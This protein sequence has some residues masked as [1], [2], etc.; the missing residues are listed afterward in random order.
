MKVQGYRVRL[1]STF[2]SAKPTA[3]ARR[4]VL[5]AG[6]RAVRG[7]LALATMI[8]PVLGYAAGAADVVVDFS[9]H[10]AHPRS[11]VGF[12][13][14]MDARRPD[15]RWVAPLEPALW[16]TGRLVRELYPRAARLGARVTVVISDI[17]GYDA[18]HAPYLNYPAFEQ[19]VRQIVRAAGDRPVIYDIWGE[20]DTATSWHGSEA[21]FMETFRRAHDAIRAV[22]PDAIIAGPS[23]VSYRRDRMQRFVA[24]CLAHHLRLDV[25]SWHEFRSGPG[26]ALIERDLREARQLF[27][28]NAQ[29]ASV[30]IKEIHLNESIHQKIQFDPVAAMAVID[31]MERGGADAAARACWREPDGKDNCWSNTL[32]GLLTV[33]EE[34]RAIWWAYRWYA[35]GA[36]FRV[37][38]D[39]TDPRVIVL[40]STAASEVPAQV[41][42][43]VVRFE[44]ESL[45]EQTLRVRLAGLGTSARATMT[46][47][48]NTG[49]AAVPAPPPSVPLPLQSDG[50]SLG[51]VLT[52]QPGTLY[53]LEIADGS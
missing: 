30:G 29:F 17:W 12:L 43:G 16:R 6:R 33:S 50:Q 49:T 5:C 51:A 48:R 7:L 32:E 26:M 38:A 24:A 45:P 53:R 36:K 20:P 23:L 47:L 2:R 18:D 14:G 46:T 1:A 9:Q 22:K 35:Q 25:L 11:M 8:T 52:L 19:R 41:L 4:A 42:L 40:A 10:I 28:E 37:H 3:G 15:D 13:H 21:Q 44:G 31:G 27:L 34:P 39:R